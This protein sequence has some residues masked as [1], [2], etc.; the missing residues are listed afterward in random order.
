MQVIDIPSS[1]E[2]SGS[3][4]TN[5]TRSTGRKSGPSKKRSRL[6]V[7]ACEPSIVE[8]IEL[9]D[10]DNDL[11][12]RRPLKKIRSRSG[13]SQSTSSAALTFGKPNAEILADAPASAS[14][15]SKHV[16]RQEKQADGGPLFLPSS[17]DEAHPPSLPVAQDVPDAPFP[18]PQPLSP[19]PSAPA[20]A[21]INP[22][23]EYIARVLEI[24]PDVQPTHAFALIEQLM[25]SQPENVV[26]FVLH[27]L[28]ENPSY[29]KVDK[30]GKHKRDESDGDHN[31]R[32]SP[33]PR[34]DYT[35]KERAYNGG[36]HYFERS[37]VSNLV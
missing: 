6:A 31:T 2:P 32:A 8:I 4:M 3:S 30:K 10:S 13:P 25:Q 20:P 23:D 14:G 24:V 26:E 5:H 19:E 33:R 16:A 28:F 22:I 18:H 37:L 1:P 9:S 12:M 29:P 34:V 36:P 21:P 35:S 17:D 7:P 27:A 11:P 15:P